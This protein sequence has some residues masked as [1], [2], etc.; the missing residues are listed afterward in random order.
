MRI[1]DLRFVP[2]HS[3]SAVI[4]Y[5]TMVV[6]DWLV[7]KDVRIINCNQQLRVAMPN[8]ERPTASPCGHGNLR[9]ANYCSVCGSR[10]SERFGRKSAAFFDIAHPIDATS[11]RKMEQNILEAMKLSENDVFHTIENTT[12]DRKQSSFAVRKPWR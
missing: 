9:T 8:K 7:I 5:A 11:R 1:S 2:D 3:K 12:S 10:I 6:D 4:A